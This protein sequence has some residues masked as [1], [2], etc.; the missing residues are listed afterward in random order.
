MDEFLIEIG[1]TRHRLGPGDSV[2][3]PR[4]VPHVWAHVGEGRGA[5]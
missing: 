4:R 1:G 5:S 2:L 3:A